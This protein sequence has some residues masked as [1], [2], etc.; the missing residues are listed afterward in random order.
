M[1]ALRSRIDWDRGWFVNLD[2]SQ[3]GLAAQRYNH[4]SLDLDIAIQRILFLKKIIQS[5]SRM[6]ISQLLQLFS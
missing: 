1:V 2:V 6:L 4:V 5:H 3:L